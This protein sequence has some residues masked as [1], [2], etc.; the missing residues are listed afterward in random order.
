MHRPQAAF[1]VFAFGVVLGS[2][3]APTLSS[4]NIDSIIDKAMKME[5]PE[6]AVVALQRGIDMVGRPRPDSAA[7]VVRLLDAV[8]DLQSKMH[9]PSEALRAHLQAR[10]AQAVDPAPLKP[11]T[12]LRSHG[13]VAADYRMLGRHSA[14]MAEVVRTPPPLALLCC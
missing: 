3:A 2:L 7:G 1:V 5:D 12:A 9:N 8:G 11:F 14:A 6:Q 13:A 4:V 10:E